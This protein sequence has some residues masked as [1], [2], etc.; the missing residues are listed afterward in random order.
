[1]T[2]S[3]GGKVKLKQGHGF[4]ISEGISIELEF[5]ITKEECLMKIQKEPQN[6]ENT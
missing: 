1:M 3:P 2:Q 6:N 4:S 5:F